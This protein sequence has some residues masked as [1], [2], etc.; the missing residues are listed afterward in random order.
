MVMNIRSIFVLFLLAGLTACASTSERP[1][2]EPETP[3]VM[4]TCIRKGADSA[5]AE[6]EI[7][8]RLRPETVLRRARGGARLQGYKKCGLVESRIL[9]QGSLVKDA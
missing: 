7:V 1:A 8:L 6:P 4:I 5:E 2:P 9:D 3:T